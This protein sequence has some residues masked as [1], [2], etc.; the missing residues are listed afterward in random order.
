MLNVGQSVAFLSCN[1]SDTCIT[2]SNA[3]PKSGILLV[4]T[5]V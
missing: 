3:K 5:K 2:Y 1:V 4:E